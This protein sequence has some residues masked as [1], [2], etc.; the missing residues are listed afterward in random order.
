MIDLFRRG[1][2]PGVPPNVKKDRIMC[3]DC[4]YHHPAMAGWQWDRCYHPEADYGS[5]VR[6]DQNATC[7]D[8]RESTNQC[9]PD[10]KWFKRKENK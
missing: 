2:W 3:S 4:V 5:V 7:A 1:W 8:A 10:G 9:E 6:N